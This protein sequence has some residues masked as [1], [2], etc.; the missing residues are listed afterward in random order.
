[1]AEVDRYTFMTDYYGNHVVRM[2]DD[3]QVKDEEY[4]LAADYDRICAAAAL[5]V[6][7]VEDTLRSHPEEL[8]CCTVTRIRCADLRKFFEPS[9]RPADSATEPTK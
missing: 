3:A 7:A 6:N 2:E 1:M 8:A 9:P 4:V 5:L